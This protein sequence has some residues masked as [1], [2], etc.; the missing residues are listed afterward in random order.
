MNLV[1]L[2]VA[3]LL[4][5][6]VVRGWRHGALVQLFGFGGAVLGLVVG[7]VLGPSVAARLIDRPG[8]GLALTTLAVLAMTMV[9]GQGIGSFLGL[10]LASVA[11]RSGAGALDSLLGV[12]VALVG[13]IVSVWI[14]ASA[15]S[16]GPVAPL[17][18]EIR[19]SE[20]LATLDAALPPPPDLFG[21]LGA[22]LDTQGYPQVFAGLGGTTAPPASPPA[23]GVVAAA[24]AAGTP[25]TVQVQALGCGGVSTGSGVVVQPGFVVT[26][27]HV[28]AGAE[29]VDVRDASGTHDAS[30][31]GFDPD[32]DVAVL[33]APATTASPLPWTAVPAGRDTAG[34]TLG[35]PGGQRELNVLATAVRSREN[36]RGRD[37]YGTGITNREILVLD[38]PV[39]PGDS[40]GPFVDS[41]GAVAGVVFAAAAVDDTIG[42]ALTAES[43]R[44][45]V[46]AAIASAQPVGTGA[47]RY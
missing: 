12:G 22:F 36:A 20:I 37:I 45:G 29:T 32:L 13:V 16:Q 43:V 47:C 34:A 10:R 2:V 21:R 31:V 30:V 35:F 44:P 4:V 3:V 26:N 11:H 1:D 39:R 17:A 42:Y 14:G 8:V 27:A 7:G 46:E 23:E 18:R 40:G 38:A 19:D 25:A 33:S 6:A 5:T 24:A 41:T 15:L 9:V 28:I